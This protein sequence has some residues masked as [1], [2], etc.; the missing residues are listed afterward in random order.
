MNIYIN[1]MF[2]VS[3][4]YGQGALMG[5][6]VAIEGSDFSKD[7]GMYQEGMEG[8]MGMK[9]KD[10]LLSNWFFV[11]GT[12]VGTLVIGALIGFLLAKKKIKKG[13]EIYED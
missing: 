1:E 11:I 13:I 12:T 3:V 4:V 6:T 10:P 7:P 5:S 8:D 9:V 2:E